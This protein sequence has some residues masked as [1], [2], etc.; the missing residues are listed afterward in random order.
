M[1][2]IAVDN[3]VLGVPYF[4]RH[5]GEAKSHGWPAKFYWVFGWRLMVL[6]SMQVG[7]VASVIE[8]ERAVWATGW[9]LFGL[10]GVGACMHWRSLCNIPGCIPISN[11]NV[12]GTLAR[13]A[14]NWE[15]LSC[16]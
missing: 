9:P 12:A 11:G 14:G 3:D 16:N 7:M 2:W 15:V 5:I 1:A 8:F 10:F 13:F 4:F 6:V